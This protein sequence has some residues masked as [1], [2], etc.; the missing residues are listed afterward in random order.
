MLKTTKNDRYTKF[1]FGQ[2]LSFGTISS[3]MIIFESQITQQCLT[4]IDLYMDADRRLKVSHIVY[5]K[6]DVLKM[7]KYFQ[8][9][10]N[11]NNISM[12]SLKDID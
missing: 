7:V 3:R 12:H 2:K 10:R 6:S 5:N 8:A 1:V 4:C 9:T 11:V